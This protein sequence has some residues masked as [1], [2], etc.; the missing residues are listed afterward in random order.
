MYGVGCDAVAAFGDYAQSHEQVRS[1]DEAGDWELAVELAT[2][3][4]LDRADQPSGSNPPADFEVFAV[5]SAGELV[6]QSAAA[7]AAF[8]KADGALAALRWAVVL[9]GLAIA[10]LAFSGYGRRLREYR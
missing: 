9:A 6:D 4:T 10:V 2:S 3:G 5:A 8:D 1:L 7:S